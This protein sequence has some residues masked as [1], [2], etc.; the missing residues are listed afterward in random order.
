M[1][2]ALKAGELDASKFVRWMVI[3]VNVEISQRR[4]DSKKPYVIRRVRRHKRSK[5]VDLIPTN[6]S[7]G[8]RRLNVVHRDLSP[9]KVRPVVNTAIVLSCILAS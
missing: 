7:S 1:T 3:K 6:S 9:S 5:A 8:R 2:C 4:P